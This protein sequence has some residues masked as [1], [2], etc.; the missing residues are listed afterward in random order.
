MGWQSSGCSRGWFDKKGHSSSKS[1]GQRRRI[2]LSELLRSP[3]FLA[4]HT[5]WV[6]SAGVTPPNPRQLSEVHSVSSIL[7]LA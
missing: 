3:L 4:T 6:S 5:H 2:L 7:H 1:R